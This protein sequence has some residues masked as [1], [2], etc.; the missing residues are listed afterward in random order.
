MEGKIKVEIKQHYHGIECIFGDMQ[1]VKSFL[2]AVIPFMKVNFE[3]EVTF[4]EEKEEEP[5]GE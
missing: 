1:E 4:I 5:D 2:D 3:V